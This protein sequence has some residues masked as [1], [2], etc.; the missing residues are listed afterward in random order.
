MERDYRSTPEYQRARR[1]RKA[2]ELLGIIGYAL[3]CAAA[4]IALVE[5]IEWLARVFI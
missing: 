5:L 4:S 2:L 1:K 3:L